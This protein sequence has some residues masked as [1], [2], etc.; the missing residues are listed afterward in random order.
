MNFLFQNLLPAD[1]HRRIQKRFKELEGEKSKRRDHRS[2][3]PLINLMQEQYKELSKL[4][5][6]VPCLYPAVGPVTRNGSR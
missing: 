6:Q 4:E 2:V 1:L 3:K 5:G